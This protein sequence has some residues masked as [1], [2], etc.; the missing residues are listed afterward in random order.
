[1]R[2]LN[3]YA[4]TFDF[5]DER[6]IAIDVVLDDADLSCQSPPPEVLPEWTRLEVLQCPNCPLNPAQVTHCPVAVNLVR[7]TDAFNDVVSHDTATITI[8]TKE[9]TYLKTCGTQ[10]GL[11]S[12]LGI[13]MAT[14]GCPILD[15]LRP[16]VRT[17]LPFASLRENLYRAVSMYILSQHVRER[18]GLDSRYDLSGLMEIYQDVSDVNHAMGNRIRAHFEKDANVNALVVLNCMAQYTAI[19]IEDGLLDEL[20]LLFKGYYS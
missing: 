5:E 13:L 6:R 17:H 10:E 12:L 16:M 14:S 8:R 18:K 4:Y 19:T 2:T 3:T 20:D 11:G 9:R 1:M 15:K 7:I